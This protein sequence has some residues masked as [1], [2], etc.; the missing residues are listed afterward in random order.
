MAPTITPDTRRVSPGV[1]RRMNLLIDIQALVAQ[2]KA[3]ANKMPMSNS[4]LIPA[5]H[6][7]MKK[8]RQWQPL[9]HKQVGDRS[10]Q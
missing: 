2:A 7:Q 8:G 3:R 5:F 9:P 10:G 6:S 4:V 1:R